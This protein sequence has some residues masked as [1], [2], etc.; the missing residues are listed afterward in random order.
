[1]RFDIAV[2]LIFSFAL[3]SSIGVCCPDDISD[4]ANNIPEYGDED[5]IIWGEE[6]NIEASEPEAIVSRPEE[7]GL[8]VLTILVNETLNYF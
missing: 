1:M 5:P 8:L 4:K 2:D 6:N 3:F 7:R